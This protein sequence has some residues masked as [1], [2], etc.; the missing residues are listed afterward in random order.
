[1][2]ESVAFNESNLIEEEDYV[3]VNA[4][5]SSS[6]MEIDEEELSYDAED[7]FVIFSLSAVGDKASTNGNSKQ[8]SLSTS[9]ISLEGCEDKFGD[10]I[11]DLLMKLEENPGDHLI[12]LDESKNDRKSHSETETSTNPD[13]IKTTEW[14]QK[15][16]KTG[17]AHTMDITAKQ[18]SSVCGSRLSN[19]KRRKRLKMMKKAAAAAE[20]AASLEAMRQKEPLSLSPSKTVRKGKL[21]K[22]KKAHHNA[23]IA[24]I[25]AT[26][27]LSQYREKHNV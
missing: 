7:D 22:S 11:D 5:E 4:N 13:E 17:K 26:E 14:T 3:L 10:E 25:C 9:V 21:L 20:A 24:V 15:T 18:E 23:N 2:M 12:N 1:M 19:K 6:N 27:S 8:S 16:D